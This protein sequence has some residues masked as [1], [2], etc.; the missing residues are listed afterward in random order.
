MFVGVSCGQCFQCT[1]AGGVQPEAGAAAV[2]Q[3]PADVHRAA[4]LPRRGR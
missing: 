2:K 3:R 4:A 1:P